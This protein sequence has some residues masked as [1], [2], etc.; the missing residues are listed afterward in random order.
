MEILRAATLVVA[1]HRLDGVAGAR[2]HQ[3]ITR[4]EKPQ[5]SDTK[6]V[7]TWGS[8]ASTPNGVRTRVSTLR[9]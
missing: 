2:H 6:R 7:A 1:H 8:T 5:V 9:A 3:M 4:D